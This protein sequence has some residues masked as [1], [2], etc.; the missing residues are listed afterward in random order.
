MT[1][2]K[3]HLQPGYIFRIAQI[4]KDIMNKNNSTQSGVALLMALGILALMSILGVAYSTNMRLMERTTRDFV[5]DMQARYLAEGGIEYA[6]AELKEDARN[7]FVYDGISGWE[8]DERDLS[9]I[10]FL[11]DVVGDINI[12]AI[13]TA[14]QINI[15]NAN[16]TLLRCIPGIETLADDI[17]LMR[18]RMPNNEFPTKQSICL[19]GGLGDSNEPTSIYNKIKNYITTNTYID[20]NTQDSGG[21]TEKRSAININTLY[22]QAARDDTRARDML[23]NILKVV[24]GIGDDRA[25]N[26]LSALANPPV[27][28]S[29]PIESWS[30]FYDIVNSA[31]GIGDTLSERINDMFN[32]N[33]W[34]PS[35][36]YATEF[37]F[38]SGGTYE[39]TATG[40]VTKNDQTL[41]KKTVTGTIKIFD[42]L[43]Q[44][45]TEQFSRN[46][47]NY[48]R[49]TW[50]DSCPVNSNDIWTLTP[51]ADPRY[52]PT[53][54][55]YIVRDSLKLGYWDN[56]SDSGY[57]DDNWSR[58]SYSRF[59]YRIGEYDR[60]DSIILDNYAAVSLF[61]ESAPDRWSFAGQEHYIHAQ[62][63]DTAQS[64]RRYYAAVLYRAVRDRSYGYD[65][66]VV[67]LYNFYPRYPE[68]PDR[69]AIRL[70]PAISWGKRVAAK[71]S[72]WSLFEIKVLNNSTWAQ[73]SYTNP[74]TGE[75]VVYDYSTGPAIYRD[76]PLVRLYN[77]QPNLCAYD[78]IRIIGTEGNYTSNYF[79]PESY[80]VDWGTVYFTDFESDS[81]KEYIKI[82]GKVS[83][84]LQTDTGGYES[85]INSPG[86]AI[87][88]G[89]SNSIM[90]KAI[91]EATAKTNIG[92]FE[93]PVL[94]DVWI[95]YLPKTKILYWREGVP[96]S[97]E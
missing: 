35:T 16:A 14:R 95:T 73:E 94:E 26:I 76:R 54:E 88:G 1:H 90:Y 49:V 56:F 28:H 83:V 19:S 2:R 11:H 64:E 48:E 84:K 74:T 62:M 47:D 29:L 32:P 3:R 81:V 41:A 86:G 93:T 61:S 69:F 87:S 6:I 43:N 79:T 21:S 66:D 55:Y 89:N 39:I 59:D 57:S 8:N 42:L 10:E 38:H 7:N 68:T 65:S 4:F 75:G 50:L 72:T 34:K 70:S 58:E 20:P 91:L 92:R 9:N 80:A 44:T 30:E 24:S 12:K 82:G 37:C 63:R 5:Y 96:E 36:T 60:H 33:R 45:T 40:T 13:D 18:N 77:G 46:V 71:P 15:N 25:E 67:H 52:T 97:S 22:R 51:S 31:S 23:K 27:P 78:N 17:I 53:R 85:T